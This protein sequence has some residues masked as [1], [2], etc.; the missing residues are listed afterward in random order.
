MST[1]HHINNDGSL[2]VL[3]KE[4]DDLNLNQ[5]NINGYSYCKVMLKPERNKDDRQKTKSVKMGQCPRWNETIVFRNISKTDMNVK[6]L[7]I[8]IMWQDKS[9]KTYMGSIR[10]T[11][12]E[13][14]S[15]E[16]QNLWRQSIERPNLWAYGKIPLRH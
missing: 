15:N 3:I 16:E 11:N 14:S 10:L 13:D 2:H 12:H 4:A 7:E 1:G 9:T 8:A 6:E 5:Y